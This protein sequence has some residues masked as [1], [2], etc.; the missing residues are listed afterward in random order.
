MDDLDELARAARQSCLRR[1]YVY[2]RRPLS[3][4]AHF[5]LVCGIAI[6]AAIIIACLGLR[7]SPEGRDQ[8]RDFL[9]AVLA[10][11]ILILLIAV[12]V[13]IGIGAKR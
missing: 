4:L 7:A 1:H 10:A 8:L 6:V 11:L 13:R 9:C 3:G 5:L 2:R 12:G